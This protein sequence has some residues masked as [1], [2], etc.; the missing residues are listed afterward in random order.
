MAVVQIF[1][2]SFMVYLRCVINRKRIECIIQLGI[3]RKNITL[4]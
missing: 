4:M 3:I 1:H 2:F